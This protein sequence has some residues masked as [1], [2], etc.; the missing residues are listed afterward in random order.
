MQI[1][2]REITGEYAIAVPVLRV[3]LM[4]LLARQVRIFFKQL[5][6]LPLKVIIVFMDTSNFTHFYN[7]KF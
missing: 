7:Q 3:I 2:L 6:Y 5:I 1:A 4:A